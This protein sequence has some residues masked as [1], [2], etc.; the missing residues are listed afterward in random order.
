V[1]GCRTLTA[2]GVFAG[3]L[4]SNPLSRDLKILSFSLQVHGKRLVEDT[5]LELSYGQV[6]TSAQDG[7]PTQRAARH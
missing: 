1:H 4:G 6:P 2:L 5:T 7:G 3:V